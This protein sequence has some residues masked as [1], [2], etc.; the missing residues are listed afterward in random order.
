MS[1]DA[2][3]LVSFGGPEG[4]G[5]VIPFL[6]RVLR[7]RRVPRERM[8]EVAEHYHHFGGVS[9]INTQNRNLIAALERELEARRLTLPV[10]WGNRNW[11]PLLPDTVRRMASDGIQR[12]L[13]I[14][15]SAY[16][17][18]SNCRQYLENIEEARREAGNGAPVIDKVR[19]F[20]H[21][22]GFIETMSER[23]RSA[24]D[25]LP[26]EGRTSAHLVYTAHS[27]PVGHGRELFI[28]SAAPG[29]VPVDQRK[30]GRIHLDA[31]LPKPQRSTRA[32]LAGTRRVRLHPVDPLGWRRP[33]H[34]IGPRGFHL[35]PHGSR[36]RSGCGSAGMLRRTRR[37]HGQGGNGGNPSAFRED[38]CGA[39]RR[40]PFGIDGPSS[41]GC[42]GSLAG[43]LPARLLSF[44]QV[45]QREWV[46][47]PSLVSPIDPWVQWNA[48]GTCRH[49]RTGGRPRPPLR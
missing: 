28:R 45:R 47:W 10:Y 29:S 36:L 15:T 25:Q 49:R 46:D 19:P 33:G 3:L 21:H 2:L 4:T 38:D 23:V 14:V 35:G 9:P 11:H 37:P 18:Y 42:A 30:R 1:Y 20:F 32:T 24:L 13:A 6:E 26:V 31:H 16:S 43:S 22:P 44:R 48:R 17:S 34:R 8:M 27:I 40:T 41:R 12:A 39:R 7:G 5:D